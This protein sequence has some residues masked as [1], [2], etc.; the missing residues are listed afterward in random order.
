M[1]LFLLIRLQK[2]S[3]LNFMIPAVSM[4]TP[5]KSSMPPRG[6]VLPERQEAREK[7][8]PDH[9]GKEQRYDGKQ[10]IPHIFWNHTA[11]AGFHTAFQCYAENKLSQKLQMDSSP[12]AGYSLAGGA[13]QFD[14]ESPLSMIPQAFMQI[15]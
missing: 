4:N 11:F 13:I 15:K 9:R 12:Y 3:L 14:L 5:S 10:R 8:K 2:Y 1:I 6:Y 7:Y